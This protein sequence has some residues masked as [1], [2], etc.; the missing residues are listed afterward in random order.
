MKLNTHTHS[1]NITCSNVRRVCK[2]F[3]LSISLFMLLSEN[4]IFKLILYSRRAE[5]KRL[6]KSLVKIHRLKLNDLSFQIQFG[7]YFDGFHFCLLRNGFCSFQTMTST[8]QY[9]D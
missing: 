3:Q 9:M 7:E 8:L 2:S 1:L 6:I 5:G 4:S